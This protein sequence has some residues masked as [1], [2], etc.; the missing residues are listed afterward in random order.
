MTRIT[1]HFVTVGTRRVHYRRAGSG[2]PVVML[3]PSPSC[4]GSLT[5]TIDVFAK[6]FT[7]IALDT[8]GYGLSDLLPMEQPEIPDFAEALAETLDALGIER[9]GVFGSHTGASI[10]IEFIRRYPERASITVFDGY[11]GYTDDY[12]A[13]MLES[14]LPPYVPKWDGTHLLTTWMKY[15]EQ[16]LYSPPFRHHKENRSNAVPCDPVT[17]QAAVTPRLMT[18]RNYNI[19]YSSVFRYK[20]LEAPYDLKSPTCFAAREDDSLVRSLGLL[21]DLPEGC[22]KEVLGRD[23]AAAAERYAEILAERLEPG[24]TPA[25]PDPENLPGRVQYSYTD[26]GAGQVM[27]RRAGNGDRPLVMMPPLPGTS[28]LLETLMLALAPARAV[29]AFDPPGNGDSD[30]FLPHTIEAC[31][32]ALGQVATK[33]A[34]G[35]FDLYGRNAGASVAAAFAHANPDRVGKLILDAPLALDTATA[36]AWQAGYA[37]AI[38]PKWDGSHLIALWHQLRAEQLF[39]PWFNE[40]AAGIRDVEPE[41]DPD[42]LSQKLTGILKHYGTYHEFWD[43][44]FEYP[45]LDTLSRIGHTTLVCARKNDLFAAFAD[46][47]AEAVPKASRATLPA[48]TQGAAR[49]IAEFLDS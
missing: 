23:E 12:R 49:V 28:D 25:P 43:V 1:R 32:G 5:G 2:P 7:A 45:G 8:P 36:E 16:F 15:R 34:V 10:A 19:G 44:A 38:E 33:L 26:F 42:F 40:T 3:H 20:S 9:C 29:I 30:D 48:E 6:A 47:A 18:G 14:Y 13:D 24:D 11:P 46:D 41:I 35:E 22:W 27:V 31:A 21:D 4:S 17:T 37:P 39:S